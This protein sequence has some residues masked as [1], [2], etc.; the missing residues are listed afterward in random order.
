ML[1]ATEF[2]VMDLIDFIHQVKLV[3]ESYGIGAAVGLPFL[4]T[5]FPFLPLFLM[6]AFNILSYGTFLGLVFTFIGTWIGTIV[7]FVF[8]RYLKST[9]VEDVLYRTR[10]IKKALFWIEDTHPLLLILVLSIPF[11]PT[12]MINYSMG[13]TNMKFSKFLWI[14]TISRTFLLLLCL[15][16]GLTLVNYY[17]ENVAGGVTVFWLSAMGMVVLVGILFGQKTKKQMDKA[18]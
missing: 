13:L 10:T 3:Y 2:T 15:P 7:I 18:L 14:T 17:K 1:L 6:A 16:F 4:E 11:S 12:F 8:M 9:K 5:L